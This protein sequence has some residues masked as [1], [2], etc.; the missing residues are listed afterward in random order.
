MMQIVTAEIAIMYAH[1]QL[2]NLSGNWGFRISID[3]GDR[4]PIG[5]MI[6]LVVRKATVDFFPL[7]H[8]TVIGHLESSGR[9]EV[10]V[11]GAKDG[12][13]NFMQINPLAHCRHPQSLKA[14]GGSGLPHS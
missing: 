5:M 12:A 10:D 6:G 8:N 9:L 13:Q 1:R 7:I 11:S 14:D 3:Y 2:G 4:I